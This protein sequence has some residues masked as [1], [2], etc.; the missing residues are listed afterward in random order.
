MKIIINLTPHDI[1]I[2]GENGNRTIPKSGKVARVEA[3][4]RSCGFFDNVSLSSVKFGAVI[5]L[6]EYQPDILLIVS[7]MVRA[8]APSR[9]DLASPGELVRDASG[10]VVGCRG[11][12]VD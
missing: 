7:A 3:E 4:S 1:V 11:L 6:P 10:A 9:P 12:I 8:A 2:V 5:E